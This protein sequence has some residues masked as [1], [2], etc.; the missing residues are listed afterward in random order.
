MSQRKAYIAAYGRGNMTDKTIDERASKLYKVDKVFTRCKELNETL[1]ATVIWDKADMIN[2]LK[3]ICDEC[4]TA[5]R[6][7]LTDTKARSV[8]VNAIRTASEILGYKAPER[9][10]LNASVILETLLKGASDKND[11]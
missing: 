8:A 9:V 2:D 3:E 11:Y 10:D 7:G 4:R 6:E 5:R 1:S